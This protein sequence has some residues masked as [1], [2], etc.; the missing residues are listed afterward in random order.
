[1]TQ[2]NELDLNLKPLPLNKEPPVE[3]TVEQV[4]DLRRE[5]EGYMTDAMREFEQ[6]TGM[7]ITS[8]G[9]MRETVA[10]KWRSS[11]YGVLVCIELK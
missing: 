10:G 4:R 11:L 1:M 5:L 8:V 2:M 9:L 6:K 7:T 3:Y